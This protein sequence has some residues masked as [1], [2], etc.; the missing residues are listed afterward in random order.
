MKSVII[1]LKTRKPQKFTNDVM[2]LNLVNSYDV[3]A[4]HTTDILEF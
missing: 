3:I 2:R 4:L 1:N